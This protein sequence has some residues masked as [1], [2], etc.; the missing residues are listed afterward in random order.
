MAN[1]YFS[2]LSTAWRYAKKDRK[3]YVVV[4]SMFICDNLITAINPFFFGWFVNTIQK[5]GANIYR[6]LWLYAI[7][8]LLLRLLEWAF[9][10]P[11]RVMERK[12]AFNLSKNYLDERYQ[13]LIHLPI[14]WHKD[15]H[16]GSTINRL[17]KAY[18][19]LKDFFELGF[20]Y[21]QTLMRF[22]ISF[23][24]MLYFSPLFGSIA[25][26]LGFITFGVILRFDKPFIA[27]LKEVNE[28]EHKVSSNLFDSL[29]NIMT[30]IT[31]RLEKRVHA[32]LMEKVDAIFPPFKR[33]IV[34]NEWKWFTAQMLVALIYVVMVAG[35]VYQHNVAGK[36]FML[37]GL[38]TLI[39][40]VTQFISVFNN[41]AEQYTQVVQY[42]TDV[43][44][45]KGIETAFAEEHRPLNESELPQDWKTIA[46]RNL[47][48]NH[49]KNSTAQPLV[50]NQ[51][52]LNVLPVWK[53]SYG[54]KEMNLE[55]LRG[56]KIALV[57]ESGCGKS[58][59]L[60]LLRG[61]YEPFSNVE[62]TVDGHSDFSFSHIANAVTLFPQEP[63]IFEATF[64]Y[65]ITLG[66]PFEKEEVKRV[67][68]ITRLSTVL[69]N[70]E[71]GLHSMIQEK[72]VNLSG[73]QKQRLALAR[74]VLA[75]RTSSIVLLDEPTSSMDQKT[76]QEIYLN[77]FSEFEGKTI[78]SSLHRLHLLT[79]FDYIYV[80]DKGRIVEEGTLQNL[81][82]NGETFKKLW[83]H[84][85]KDV[86]Q[87]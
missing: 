32:G 7:G 8:Y 30:V 57:G 76:E 80:L 33:N 35:Y 40:F 1:P 77:L 3:L 60:S 83:N 28:A 56:Q 10:G 21:F 74:G 81:L 66:L 82:E 47:N 4:Y 55:L 6:A 16:S 71:D 64:E 43:E 15:H 27:S 44:T 9:H 26:I 87:N 70:L 72:G 62:L 85:H 75:A 17:R 13:Q 78:I 58:T 84:R 5:N 63:E 79:H 34:V 20:V 24:V 86:T 68:E 29:S 54:L 50:N 73:G 45:A 69:E 52:L 14:G 65:N 48:F 59:L 53:K 11:A 25:I 41:F 2:L 22:I 51:G 42:H 18:T 67:S 38:V 12:L 19:A 61:L 49:P 37:G 39:G 31:L 46:I 36:V 23:S